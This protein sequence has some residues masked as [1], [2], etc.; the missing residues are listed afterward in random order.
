[1]TNALIIFVRNPEL[2][3]VKT[4][5]AAQIGNEKALAVYK[6]LLQHTKEITLPASAEKYVFYTDEINNNDLW[7]GYE[8]QTQAGNNLGDRMQNAFSFL[9][10]KGYNKVCIIGSDCHELTTAIIETAF[11]KLT[12]TDVVIGPAVDGGYYLLGMKRNTKTLFEGIEWSTSKVFTSTI[13]KINERQL[14]CFT[15]PVL[16]DVDEANDINFSY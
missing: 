12:T 9:F 8:K 15:L 16:T 10:G 14:S 13:K 11:E 6:K 5:L 4:R 3:K 1:M 7:N 2:G